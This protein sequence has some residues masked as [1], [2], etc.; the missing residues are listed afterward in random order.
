[1]PLY[2]AIISTK[3]MVRADS[4]DDAIEWLCDNGEWRDDLWNDEFD[5]HLVE[6]TQKGVVPAEWETSVPFGPLDDQDVALT[7]AEIL[8]GK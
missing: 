2:R 3:I 5:M 7:C 4:K 1:M 8:E 6:V